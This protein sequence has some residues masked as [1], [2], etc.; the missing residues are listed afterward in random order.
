MHTS[1]DIRGLPPH[2]SPDGRPVFLRCYAGPR[3][4]L[5]SVILCA[6]VLLAGLLGGDQ[7]AAQRP[8]R[9]PQAAAN[10]QAGQFWTMVTPLED[11]RQM[12]L[13]LAPHVEIEIASL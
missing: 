1:P 9:M 3:A 12:L 7:A 4:L 11:G 13:L 6:G 10:G 2:A 5:G 8:A